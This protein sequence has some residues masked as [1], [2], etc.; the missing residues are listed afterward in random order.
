VL[1][2]IL[3]FVFAIAVAILIALIAGFVGNRNKKFIQRF[4]S[5]R[6]DY[7]KTNIRRIF[8]R[9]FDR[10]LTGKNLIGAEV[11]VSF[12]FHAKRLVAKKNVAVLYCVDPYAEQG[13]DMVKESAIRRLSS[14]KV[15]WHFMDSQAASKRFA[16]LDFVYLDAAH[17]EK[18]V[19]AD[20][21]AWWSRIKP[22]GVLGGHD[23]IWDGV[24]AAVT[25]WTVKNNLKLNANTPDWWVRKPI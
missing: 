12:G 24:I 18:S 8:N 7:F 2:H 16:L 22:G 5:E 13:L 4:L 1:T 23:F 17:D 20:I 6:F 19:N 14:S 11:G 9:P 15:R 3:Y 25:Q 21:E 10:V